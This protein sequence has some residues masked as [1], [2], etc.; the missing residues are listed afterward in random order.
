M[1]NNKNNK[2]FFK[3]L[4]RFRPRISFIMNKFIP[5]KNYSLTHFTGDHENMVSFSTHVQQLTLGALYSNFNNFNFYSIEHPYIDDFQI[6]NNKFNS[7]FS[8]L[9]KRYRF[10]YFDRPETNYF[11]RK[12]YFSNDE[13]DFPIKDEEKQNYID[14]FHSFNKEYLFEKLLIKR[15]IKIDDDT[16]VLHIRTGDIFYGDWHSLYNQNPLSYYLKIS[17]NFKKVLVISGKENNNPVLK[18]LSN[19]KKFSFQ[20]S[21]FIDDFNV[22]LNAKNLATSGVSGFPLS[23]ALMSQKLQN[24]YHSD[25]YLKEHLNPE[26]LNKEI[27]NVHSYKILDYIPLKNFVKNDVNL[28]KLT[29]DDKSKIIK[30]N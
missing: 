3:N 24:F 2:K 17:E 19:Y 10:F 9:K 30:V 7:Y 18:L 16:L 20:S 23:A 5:T 27:L 12:N 25:L 29:S 4:K 15:D 8:Y 26:M 11:K 28:S 14:N 21:N 22:L 6:I 13:N 1:L